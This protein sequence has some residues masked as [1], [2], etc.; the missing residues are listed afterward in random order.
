MTA[1]T[2]VVADAAEQAQMSGWCDRIDYPQL[3]EG[4]V[5][6]SKQRPAD[7]VGRGGKQTD[8]MY[9]AP[10]GAKFRSIKTAM[11]YITD[12]LCNGHKPLGGPPMPPPPAPA[13]P[14][15]KPKKGPPRAPRPVKEDPSAFGANRAE[16]EAICFECGSGEEVIG[17]EI[18]L[19]DGSGCYAAFHLRCLERP[20]FA[21][22]EGDW[23]CPGCEPPA[24]P[25]E[26][27]ASPH[28]KGRRVL[29]SRQNVEGVDIM[30][31]A[32]DLAESP[33][34]DAPITAAPPA[35]SMADLCGLPCL[36]TPDGL[37]QPRCGERGER[38]HAPLS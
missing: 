38:M 30:R 3:G 36:Y 19:C 6:L 18:L 28:V 9:I 21:V 32:R 35:L 14:K 8:H 15:K 34:A 23:L 26:K 16:A 2:L 4:W 10:S 7:Q 27:L 11:D 25:P 1:G 37:S 33:P 13:K 22:P 29:P 24:P 5:R 12:G 31:W 17:N 20:L